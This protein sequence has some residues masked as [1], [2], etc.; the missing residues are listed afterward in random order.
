MLD[1]RLHAAHEA[2]ADHRAHRPAH[3]AE[4]EGRRHDGRILE[5]TAHHDQRLLLGGLLLG[6]REP[7]LVFLQILELERIE[8]FEIGADLLAT[9]GSRKA[10]S[11]RRA[12]RRL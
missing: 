3:E 4:L 6:L 11:R 12:L 2:L 10:S 9:I 5:P 7:L 1:R 8:R